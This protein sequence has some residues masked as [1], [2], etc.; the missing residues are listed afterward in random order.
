ML[1]SDR[2]EL[3]TNN[4]ETK[5]RK[6]LQNYNYTQTLSFTLVHKVHS[7]LCLDGWI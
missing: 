7:L 3:A 2:G 5:K 1:T 4:T 6:K